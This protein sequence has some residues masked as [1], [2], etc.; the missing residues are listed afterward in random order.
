M[1]Q[2]NPILGTFEDYFKSELAQADKQ[3]EEAL[4]GEKKEIKIW[5]S[6]E[7]QAMR[8]PRSGRPFNILG[9][10]PTQPDYV[11]N[12]I[13][14]MYMRVNQPYIFWN[15]VMHEPMPQ[16]EREYLIS[17]GVLKAETKEQE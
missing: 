13:T 3:R 12:Y 10:T 17:I 15:K 1:S 14:Q 6:E 8:D 5:S 11:G 2:E 9:L 4:G 16:E 7:L